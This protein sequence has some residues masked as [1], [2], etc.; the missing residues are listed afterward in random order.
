MKKNNNLYFKP[1]LFL[2]FFTG[3]FSAFA[4]NESYS[5][6]VENKI[7]ETIFVNLKDY[8]KDFVYDMKYATEDNFL[9]AK[10]YDCAECFLRYKTVKA[11]IAANNDFIKKG[12]RIKLYDCY[13]PLSIQKKMWEIVS[14]PKYVADPKKGSIHNRGGAVDISLVDLNGKEVEM[15]TAFDFFGPEAGHNYIK[16][17]KEILANRK[18]LKKIMT[19]NGFNSFDSEW[20][21]YNLKAGLKDNVSNQKWNCN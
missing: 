12:F 6:P 9:K 20:W 8:S 18:F 4:Q 2:G 1:F 7:E 10:V 13:R 15:G 14:N 11:L 17:S 19:Q 3:I 5:E 21:H 16:F